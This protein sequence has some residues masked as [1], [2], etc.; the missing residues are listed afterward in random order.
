MAKDAHAH[1]HRG[2]LRC[3]GWGVGM[4][5]GRQALGRLVAARRSSRERRHSR[6]LHPTA[7]LHRSRLWLLSVPP[8]RR[9]HR[10]VRTARRRRGPTIRLPAPRAPSFAAA[11]RAAGGPRSEPPPCPAHPRVHPP[12]T[13]PPQGHLQGAPRAVQPRVWRRGL[14][15]W[16]H[17]YCGAPPPPPHPPRGTNHARA[18]RA[19]P[20]RRLGARCMSRLRCCAPLPCWAGRLRDLGAS[21]APRYPLNTRPPS[22]P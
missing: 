8:H 6:P 1:G 4:R 15:H 10:D 2:L 20:C 17:L 9:Q 5:H 18:A 19:L 3:A 12:R 21:C 7:P 13:P 11:R 14:P 22:P 16:L